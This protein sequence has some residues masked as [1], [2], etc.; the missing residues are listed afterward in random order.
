MLEDGEAGNM[1]VF[2]IPKT[3]HEAQLTLSRKPRRGGDFW[4]FSAGVVRKGSDRLHSH[5]LCSGEG[6]E[7][8]E[9]V[10]SYL[11]RPELKTEV[12]ASVKE[13]SRHVDQDD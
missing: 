12:I 5:Y 4:L 3:D 10:L 11:A 2:T 1:F 8:K 13:L 6:Q 9:K 7:G